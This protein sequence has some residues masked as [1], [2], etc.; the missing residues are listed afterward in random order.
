MANAGCC[1]G[2][3]KWICWTK[4]L[5]LQWRSSRLAALPASQP[6]SQPGDTAHCSFNNCTHNMYCCT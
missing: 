3:V 1:S 2:T 4:G 6:A 5:Q